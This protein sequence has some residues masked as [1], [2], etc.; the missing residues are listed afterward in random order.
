[1]KLLFD[2]NL[3]P[4][5]VEMLSDIFPNSIHVRSV[6][7][8]SAQDAEIWDFAKK[9]D[10]TVVTKDADF[11]ERVLLFNSPPRVIWIRRGNCSTKEIEKILRE[12]LD[13]INNQIE[14]LLI[15]II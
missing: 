7:L 10:Y 5:L 3:S 13:E 8:D 12:N 2:Q 15:N 1:M 14:L 9:K 4:H 11:A 6:Q